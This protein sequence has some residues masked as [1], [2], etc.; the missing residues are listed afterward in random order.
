METLYPIVFI[1][2][3]WFSHNRV[4]RFSASSSVGALFY[5]VLGGKMMK[6]VLCVVTILLLLFSTLTGCGKNTE[7]SKLW[8]LSY[9]EDEFKEPTDECYITNSKYFEGTFSNTATTDS[10]LYVQILADKSRFSIKLLEYG[11]NIVEN[12]S[13]SQAVNY[14]IT[15]KYDDGEKSKIYADMQPGEDEIT[16]NSPYG[17]YLASKLKENKSLSFYICESKRTT[18]NYL[19]TVMSD[20]FQEIYDE[21]FSVSTDISYADTDISTIEK[22]KNSYNTALSLA[23]NNNKDQDYSYLLLHDELVSL[24][25]AGT[26]DQSKADVIFKNVSNE[27]IKQKCSDLLTYV[28]SE[29]QDYISALMRKFSALES[30]VG[31][32]EIKKVNIQVDDIDKLLNELGIQPETLGRILAMLDIYDYSW[33]SDSG[34][35]KFLQFTNTGF[36]Y[37]WTAVGDKTLVL[38]NE[39][40]NKTTGQGNDKKKTESTSN[41]TTQQPEKPKQITLAELQ[42]T[43]KY[44]DGDYSETVVISGNSISWREDFSQN[45]LNNFGQGDFYILGEGTFTIKSDGTDSGLFI[46]FSNRARYYTDGSIM[47]LDTEMERWISSWSTSYFRMGNAYFYKQ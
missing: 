34:D 27:N 32:I 4:L 29:D 46:S 22:V 36:T 20:N 23:K 44:S 7:E 13:S 26:F 33:L 45:W 2:A 24:N 39:D 11:K 12:S 35:N 9:Y 28:L 41:Q 8:V 16:M 14:T 3:N 1:S 31:T 47:A 38:G 30:V 21:Q 18:T 19:F 43:W 10:K 17:Y 6:R 5:C 25:T 42:G 15:I 40:L 37:N